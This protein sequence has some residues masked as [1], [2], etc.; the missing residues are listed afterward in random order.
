MNAVKT[1]RTF[2]AALAIFGASVSVGYAADPMPTPPQPNGTIIGK[3][4]DWGT[5]GSVVDFELDNRM[6]ATW[7]TAPATPGSMVMKPFADYYSFSLADSTG[8]NALLTPFNFTRDSISRF[9][10][11][12]FKYDS[13]DYL[14]PTMSRNTV[15]QLIGEANDDTTD[16]FS[17]V[18]RGTT[19]NLDTASTLLSSGNYFLAVSGRITGLEGG[20]YLG[21]AAFSA[22]NP[23]PEP[24]TWA[25]VFVGVGMVGFALRRQR[26]GASAAVAS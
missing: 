2:G 6:P 5:I 3:N 7:W 17:L 24:E 12:L 9:D 8:F 25:M 1:A 19:L 13:S 18:S 26:R 20:R 4:I 14:I 15:A 11:A 22:A 10:V 16:S 23:V 21:E